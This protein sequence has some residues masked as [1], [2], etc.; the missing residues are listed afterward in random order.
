[1]FIHS[2]FFRSVFEVEKR[3]ESK[4]KFGKCEICFL[5]FC[6]LDKL[7]RGSKC[8]DGNIIFDQ[9]KGKFDIVE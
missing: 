2:I 3:Q 5:E 9:Q 8:I 6:L 7:L 1:M 4:K